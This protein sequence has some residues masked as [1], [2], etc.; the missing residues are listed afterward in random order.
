MPPANRQILSEL[1]NILE[2]TEIPPR[3]VGRDGEEIVLPDEV[4]AIL[5]LA[6]ADLRMGRAVSIMPNSLTMTTQQAA[7][8]LGISRPTLVKLLD[9][10]QIPFS[11][12]RRHRRIR[13]DELLTYRRSRRAERREILN[14]LTESTSEDATEEPSMDDVLAVLDR[15]RHDIA[16][17]G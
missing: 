4:F 14:S 7:D 12:P 5:K 3:L 13:L 2:T 6:V 16:G 17:L 8:F 15:K 10:G 11:R 9:E 1:A